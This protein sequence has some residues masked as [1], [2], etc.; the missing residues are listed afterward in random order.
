M[1]NES[2]SKGVVET[3]KINERMMHTL[4]FFLR[5]CYSEKNKKCPTKICDLI[6]QEPKNSE[7]KKLDRRQIQGFMETYYNFRNQLGYFLNIN[8]KR[9]SCGTK[10]YYYYEKKNPLDKNDVIDLMLGLDDSLASQKQV[11]LAKDK[12]MSLLKEESE[13]ILEL[14]EK[15]KKPKSKYSYIFEDYLKTLKS[16]LDSR[17]SIVDIEIM[18][19]GRKKLVEGYVYSIGKKEH[20][21]Y[22][23]IMKFNGELIDISLFDI[24]GKIKIKRRNIFDY[25]EPICIEPTLISFYVLNQDCGPSALLRFKELYRICDWKTI[26]K[27]V[28]ETKE[29]N[30][31]ISIKTFEIEVEA[32][33]YAN[34][35]Y[36][37]KYIGKKTC[38][39]S[40]VMEKDFIRWFLNPNVYPYIRIIEPIDLVDNILG[41]I[42]QMKNTITKNHG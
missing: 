28:V 5:N 1:L 21:P 20:E 34:V 24:T 8:I 13:E 35:N 16:V 39:E 32:R 31:K 22:V 30:N 41:I 17:R 4:L 26:D 7:D 23:K 6:N 42:V 36:N 19:D 29:V 15:R 27:F 33:Y 38:Y 40:E 14:Y 9:H 37:A 2:K 3:T 25:P 10:N 11:N 18:Q 12:I